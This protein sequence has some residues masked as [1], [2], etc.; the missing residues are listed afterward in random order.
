[1]NT[2]T[3]LQLSSFLGGFS[4]LSNVKKHLL[5]AGREVLAAV[6]GVLGF[7]EQ[8]VSNPSGGSNGGT[9]RNRAVGSAIQ[10]AQKTIREISQRLPHGNEGDYR[11]LHRKV[12]GSI[13]DVLDQEIEK[14]SGLNVQFLNLSVHA[15]LIIEECVESRSNHHLKP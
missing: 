8:Y 6:E 10:F 12:M 7:A 3:L 14:S 9:D 11:T 13:L 4:E 1:M 5:G 15:R 2:G